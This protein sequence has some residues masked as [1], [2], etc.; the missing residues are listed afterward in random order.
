MWTKREEKEEN[1]IER[2]RGPNG[3]TQA[4][5]VTVKF[6]QKRRKKREK[7]DKCWEKTWSRRGTW[8]VSCRKMSQNGAK[9]GRGV[10][11]LGKDEKKKKRFE[12]TKK[13]RRGRNH[14]KTEKKKTRLPSS[15]RD[16]GS[17]LRRLCED[18]FSKKNQLFRT[19]EGNGNVGKQ[20]ALRTVKGVRDS[21]QKKKCQVS[22]GKK[23][24]KKGRGQLTKR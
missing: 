2:R 12:K 3:K 19:G 15:C 9:P 17:T 10:E 16:T 6:A 20:G 14:P 18:F 21:P 5:K 24:K 13:K 1:Q 22:K 4:R 7:D 23:R 8:R 11:N